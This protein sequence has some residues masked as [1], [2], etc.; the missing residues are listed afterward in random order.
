M[1]ELLL[2]EVVRRLEE[3]VERIGKCLSLLPQ[4]QL[5][6]KPGEKLVSVGNLINHLCGN[7]SQWVLAGLGGQE[8][9]R[10]R[11]EEFEVVSGESTRDLEMKF[12][13]VV[14]KAV[15]VVKTLSAEDLRHVY[16][17][18]GFEETGVGILLHVTEHL[19]YHVGQITFYVKVVG[20]TH[21]GYYDEEELNA[22]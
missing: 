18:Q 21:T 17:V 22:C 10:T 16:I 5:W 15:S 20:N 9:T 12:R 19:S 8:Y 11:K 6:R 13:T 2:L 3:G 7:I 14:S 1:E 4:D